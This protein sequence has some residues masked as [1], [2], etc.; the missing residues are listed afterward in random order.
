MCILALILEVAAL[1][2]E[3]NFNELM[4]NS[5]FLNPKN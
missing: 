5:K 3:L 4:H 2:N 1:F